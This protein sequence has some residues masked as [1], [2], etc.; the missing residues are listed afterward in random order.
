MFI[1]PDGSGLFGLP[2]DLAGANAPGDHVV[3]ARGV[4]IVNVG[5]SHATAYAVG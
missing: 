5:S 1:A 2:Q 4:G 3:T